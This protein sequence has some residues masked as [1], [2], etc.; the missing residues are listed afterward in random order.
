MYVGYPE[1]T[2]D[3]SAY[4]MDALFLDGDGDFQQA[5]IKHSSKAVL[6]SYVAGQVYTVQQPFLPPLAV[7]ET[8]PQWDRRTL[9]V[10]N[11]SKM[12]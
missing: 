12:L 5:K 7:A 1:T 9:F 11:R 2:F 6:E 3:K 4:Q 10:T 8:V